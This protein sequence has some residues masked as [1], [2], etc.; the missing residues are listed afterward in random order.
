MMNLSILI[1]KNLVFYLDRTD[2]FNANQAES[3][4]VFFH[5]VKDF[6][7]YVLLAQSAEITMKNCQGSNI[8]SHFQNLLYLQGITQNEANR[9][10]VF[11]FS[12]GLPFFPSG[13]ATCPG[14]VANRISLR[15]SRIFRLAE[16]VNSILNFWGGGG[17]V[18]LG[19]LA[20]DKVIGVKGVIFSE[21]GEGGAIFLWIGKEI[22]PSP[23]KI[24]KNF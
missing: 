20:C 16:G 12:S 18:G 4:H 1:Q 21:E 11:E 10:F 7:L 14:C 19:T 5:F 2:L 24:R 3:E 15:F 17:E 13:I 23:V 9:I 6:D 8:S 22:Q